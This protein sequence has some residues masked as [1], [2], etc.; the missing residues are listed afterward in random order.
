MEKKGKF[1]ISEFQS[2][3]SEI[4]KEHKSVGRSKYVIIALLFFLVLG[5][6]FSFVFL[7]KGRTLNIEGE[8]QGLSRSTIKEEKDKGGNSPF[9]GIACQ[10]FLSRAFGIV[11]HLSP[12]TMPLSSSSEADIV[13]ESPVTNANGITRILAIFQCMSPKE[14][15]SIRSIRPFMADLAL[16]FDV[17]IS[18]W[19]GSDS[20]IARAKE[21]GVDLLDARVNPSGAF[22]RK[23]NI[24]APHNG[25]TSLEAVRKAAKDLK[26]R[27]DN[28]F[29]GYKFLD[30]SDIIYQKNEQAVEIDY[31]YPVKYI[32][33]SES[34]DYL[35]FWNGKEMLDRNNGKQIFAKNVVLMKTEIGVLSEGVANVKVIGEGGAIIYQAGKEIKGKWKKENPKGKLAFFDETGEEIK[36]IPGPIWIE[37]TD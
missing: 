36:F 3:N 19:G 22:F 37:I 29:L 16:G 2:R 18:S 34:G 32:Y 33:N 21:L 28:Q 26:M 4:T 30:N 11:L 23:T 25:F 5:S 14:I 13:I 9:S 31:Y 7:K 15:G 1:I 12:E 6:F 24:P 8:P 27:E 35:R 20:G 17:V 10:D